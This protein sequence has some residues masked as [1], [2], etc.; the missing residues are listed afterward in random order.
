MSQGTH[1]RRGFPWNLAWLTLA[2]GSVGYAASRAPRLSED[3]VSMPLGAFLAYPLHHMGAAEPQML[4]PLAFA[5]AALLIA[6]TWRAT[7]RDLVVWA[8]LLLGELLAF[9]LAYASGALWRAD[10]TRIFLGSAVDGP[11]PLDI[12]AGPALLGLLMLFLLQAYPGWSEGARAYRVAAWLLLLL[13]LPLT[14]IAAL[15]AAPDGPAGP[16]AWLRRWL[17]TGTPTATL[18]VGACGLLVFGWAWMHG[19]FRARRLHARLTDS[20]LAALALLA[21]AG[22]AWHL[23]GGDHATLLAR[24]YQTPTLLLESSHR[25]LPWAALSLVVTLWVSVYFMRTR[26]ERPALRASQGRG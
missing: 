12:W 5:G 25:G 8:P 18:V 4:V 21:V 9:A 24:A 26:P 10:E 3:F 20:L 19:T 6:T 2:L 7:D 16:S 11:Y 14:L 22:A 17:E 1:P 23:A 15:G 13:A